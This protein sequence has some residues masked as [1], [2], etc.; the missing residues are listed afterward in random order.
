MCT[1]YTNGSKKGVGEK[2][3][4]EKKKIGRNLGLIQSSNINKIHKLNALFCYLLIDFQ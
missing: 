4:N 3:I 1:T 2:K